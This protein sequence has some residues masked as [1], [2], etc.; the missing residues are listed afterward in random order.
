MGEKLVESCII[1]KGYLGGLRT[2]GF[3]SEEFK[4]PGRHEKHAAAT[5]NLGTVSAF[6]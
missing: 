4:T 6:S 1:W 2:K 5:W 3:N